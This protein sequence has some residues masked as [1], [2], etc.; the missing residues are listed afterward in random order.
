[1]VHSKVSGVMKLRTVSLIVALSSALF[2]SSCSVNNSDEATFPQDRPEP[3]PVDYCKPGLGTQY[4]VLVYEPTD[5]EALGRQAVDL[6]GGTYDDTSEFTNS[7]L[8]TL[9]ERTL[10]AL[11]K[12]PEVRSI[13]CS[14]TDIP[15]P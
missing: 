7:F 9:P 11:R 4:I 14:Q 15:P 8:A 12:H 10:E 5:P 6:F 13:E 1:M 2:L 3:A